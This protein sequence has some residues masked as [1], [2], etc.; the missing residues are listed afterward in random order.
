MLAN[1]LL[2]GSAKS[3][4]DDWITLSVTYSNVATLPR[5]RSNRNMIHKTE[6]FDHA[7]RYTVSQSK[8]QTQLSRTIPRTQP[9]ELQFTLDSMWW[10][11]FM[12]NWPTFPVNPDHAGS[13][14]REPAWYYLNANK[15][16]I[17]TAAGG[18]IRGFS[19]GSK[20]RTVRS[21][22]IVFNDC[23]QSNAMIVDFK[24]SSTYLQAHDSTYR[25]DAAQQ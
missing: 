6:T 20:M 12:I 25:A 2:S 7:S 16:N 13:L 18:D 19:P 14:R 10:S 1:S 15:I 8:E 9:H 17:M 11:A 21:S 23:I 24:F 4:P 3:W 5:A 22:R